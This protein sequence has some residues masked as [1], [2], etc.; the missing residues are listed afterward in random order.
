MEEIGNIG[1]AESRLL[2]Q[3]KGVF[4]HI[5]EAGHAQPG[6]LESGLEIL[7]SLR[8]LIYEDMNQLQHE[9]LILQ[10]A[11]LLQAEFYP[12]IPIKWLWN[13]RQT[14]GKDEPD[15]QGLDH[16]RVIVSAEI[17]TSQNPKGGIGSRMA[18]TLKKLSAMLG[19]KYYVVA[20]EDMEQRAKLKLNNLGYQINVLRL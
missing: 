10:T 18:M 11:K 14:G 17:T 4:S 16:E 19:D 1:S 9:A 2:A 15:L 7:N 8:R 13:P 20:T 6:N 12:A 3:L 5:R